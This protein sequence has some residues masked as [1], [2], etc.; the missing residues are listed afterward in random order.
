MKII[1]QNPETGKNAKVNLN[2]SKDFT[3]NQLIHQALEQF[4]LQFKQQSIGVS[5]KIDDNYYDL[6]PLDWETHNAGHAMSKYDLVFGYSETGINNNDS[7]N[8]WKLFELSLKSR[9]D[10]IN[11]AYIIVVCG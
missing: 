7:S 1:F 4:N 9:W 6:S 11:S 2:I 10:S 3:V 5:L 8:N